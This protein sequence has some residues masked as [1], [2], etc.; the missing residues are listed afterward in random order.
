MNNI[1]EGI[2]I[3]EGDKI[4]F[5]DDLFMYK[6]FGGTIVTPYMATFRDKEATIRYV[7]GNYFF[8]KEDR[9]SFKFSKDMIKKVVIQ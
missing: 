5:K 2:M 1:S 7:S 3:K 9:L 6:R 8:I 4:I